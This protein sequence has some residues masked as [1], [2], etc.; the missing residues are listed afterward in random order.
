MRWIKICLLC[1][2]VIYLNGCTKKQAELKLWY[3]SPAKEWY[4]EA[5]PI[6]NG[7]LAALIKGDVHEERIVINEETLFAGGPGEYD[8][9]N[10]GNRKD[11]SKY[12]PEVQK[13]LR[14]GKHE[15]ADALLK[16][17]LL[18]KLRGRTPKRSTKVSA[19]IP[20]VRSYGDGKYK[21]PGYGCYQPCTDL[22]VTTQGSG[23]VEDYRRELDLREGMVHISYKQGD[24]EFKRSAFASY[25]DNLLVFHFENDA[26][27][28][29]DYALHLETLQ[30]QDT[31][32]YSDRDGLILN[33]HLENNGMEFQVALKIDTDADKVGF[34]NGKVKLSQASY[35]DI[36]LTAC[37]DYLPVYP[38]YRGR[39]YV[40]H[41][42]KRLALKDK[43][44]FRHIYNHHWKDY[45]KLFSRVELNLGED[46]YAAIPTDQRLLAYGKGEQDNAL[47][48]LYFQYG[49]Y[50][51]MS[52]SRET[53]LPANLQGKWNVQM[54]P[55]W[56]CD[57]HFNIN[58]QMN[59]WPAEMTNLSESHMAFLNYIESLVEPGRKS[60]ADYFGAVGW[61]VSTMNVPFGY[62]GNGWGTW[63]YFP[64]GGA[65][66]C[67]HLWEHYQYTQDLEFL[68]QKAYPVIKEAARFWLSYLTEDEDGYLVSSPSYSPEH[69]GISTGASM[70]Q[71]IVW[72]LFSNIVEFGKITG[73]D[74]K[75]IKRIAEARERLLQ[76]KVGRLGQLQEW[77]EDRDDPN[78]HHRHVSH[79][80]A[81]YPGNQIQ[82]AKTPKLAKAA[83]K[84]L[85]LRGN[86][87]T[88]WS[89]AWKMNFWARLMDADQAYGCLRKLLTPCSSHNH[90]GFKIAGGT[91]PNLL[92]AHPPFQ[93]DGNMGGTAGIAEMLIQSHN[94][95][96][97]LLPAVPD[98]W[99]DGEIKGFV[100]RGGFVVDMTWSNKAVKEL[101]IYSKA[102]GVCT[103]ATNNQIAPKGNNMN[104]KIN[105]EK[106]TLEIETHKGES[107]QFRGVN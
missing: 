15:E 69:G 5:L 6:G 103:I 102:G 7:K 16:A 85:E 9:Y 28:G 68:K 49:R 47:E 41:N 77:K 75:F 4:L 74:S 79:L 33:G 56:A 86:G 88:G 63:G 50:L 58:V 70:D 30:V 31:I 23:D 52:S 53:S 57:Y 45:Q 60:A 62:T 1:V 89:L 55:Q 17:Q 93:L 83:R 94:G 95:E 40:M 90:D 46:Q 67:R 54:D 98:A 87:G 21:H 100:A 81:L 34:D 25:P 39:N 32:M 99:K 27:E 44:N 14:E 71:Q 22:V 92:C 78:D 11:A 3:N 36:F 42:R 66:A 8:D 37:S 73:Q 72:D 82:V 43:G 97:V 48:A 80:Y 19:N 59:Y 65:W 18:S 96:I 20:P 61:T 38:H 2:V 29:V 84:S 10:G 106:N 51:L 13:L 12:L 24:T 107:Y 91:Y 101:T 104:C 64:A 105:Q 76:P 26:D 35:I